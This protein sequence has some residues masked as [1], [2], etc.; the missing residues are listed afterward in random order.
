MASY[1]ISSD[2]TALDLEGIR[3]ADVWIWHSL[4]ADQLRASAL[5]RPDAVISG[6][7][8]MPPRG[9]VQRLIW[10]H[11][12]RSAR[13]ASLA[14]GTVGTIEPNLTR[15]FA[16]LAGRTH[17]ETLPLPHSVSSP[18]SVPKTLLKTVGFFGYQRHEKGIAHLESLVNE[19]LANDFNVIVQDSGDGVR[20]STKS[21]GLRRYGYVSEL[22]PLMKE[23]EFVILPYDPGAFARKC[24]GIASFAIACGIPVLAPD[25]TAIA[26]V[27]KR[28]DT[29]LV[30]ADLADIVP[31]MMKTR[32]NYSEY[33][34]RALHAATLWAGENGI[35][36]HSRALT[37][38][39][40]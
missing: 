30:Y 3:K 6:V 32:A 36:K 18:L 24:S 1:F 39:K 35:E 2:Q 10:R 19:F 25:R 29:G 11:A 26:Q 23:A 33:A 34:D 5:V 12:F 8:H 28:Y 27:L 15:A 21:P 7:I 9:A 16:P 14:L 38:E 17:L 37:G 4:F 13:S 22:A 40:I 31:L 20:F